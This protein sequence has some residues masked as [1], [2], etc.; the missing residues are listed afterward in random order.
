MEVIDLSLLNNKDCKLI[1]RSPHKSIISAPVNSFSMTSAILLNSSNYDAQ[2]GTLRYRFP[3]PFVTA[4]KELA[5][6]VATFYNSFFNVSADL[7]NN[8]Y[9]FTFPIYSSQGASSP[10][11]T[12]FTLTL[13]DGYYTYDQL[14][15]AFENFFIQH[16]LFMTS[17]AGNVYF[18]T[19]AVNSSAYALQLTSFYI[20]N[21]TTAATL[22]WAL[23]NASVL[24]FNNTGTQTHCPQL[25][26]TV[27]QEYYLGLDAG[28]Y[29]TSNLAQAP[30]STIAYSILGQNA[31]QVDNVTSVIVRCNMI[32]N[33]AVGNP[34]DMIA[35]IPVTAGF[36]A[37]TVAD[38][39]Y[40]IFST[41][42]NGSFT[43][44]VLSFMSQDQEPLTFFDTSM[45]FTIIIQDQ[46]R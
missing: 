18:Y 21:K 2:S 40:P 28:T 33:S 20:P 11:S 7:G 4:N 26:T 15:Y 34:V 10:T 27:D 36:G 14:N 13:N 32:N 22:G 31:P 37:A 45:S 35:Q 6:V 41:V 38:I 19:V 8:V 23:G 12:T 24:L 44:L 43:E 29:P 1:L 17:I 46:K 16:G 5:L 3:S 39:N 30:Y 9:T 25:T 42:S